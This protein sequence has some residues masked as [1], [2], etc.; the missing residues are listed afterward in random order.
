M[1]EERHRDRAHAADGE[2][3][4]VGLDRVDDATHVAAEEER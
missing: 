4:D 3:G 1:P 2:V